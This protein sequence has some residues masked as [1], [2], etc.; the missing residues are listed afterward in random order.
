LVKLVKQNESSQLAG[1][2][3]QFARHKPGWPIFL[4]QIQMFSLTFAATQIPSS[5]ETSMNSD[6]H[7]LQGIIAAA[8]GIYAMIYLIQAVI[9]IVPTWFISKKAGLSPWL[10]LL[11]LFPL[12]G[13][14]LLYILAFAEW[15]VIPAPQ[16]AFQP[17]YPPQ[18]PFPPQA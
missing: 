10:S 17:P 3:R 2:L 15:K 12:T 4:L 9:F 7:Q 8:I 13:V 14:I 16:M 1:G 18:P 11:C 6:P 5:G